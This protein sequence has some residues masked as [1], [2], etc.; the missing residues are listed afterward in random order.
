MEPNDWLR[1]EEE[2]GERVKLAEAYTSLRPKNMESTERYYGRRTG[3]G[4]EDDL[5][6]LLGGGGGGGRGQKGKSMDPKELKRKVSQCCNKM[7]EISCESRESIL[8]LLNELGTK[9]D[10]F[11]NDAITKMMESKL[12]MRDVPAFVEVASAMHCLFKPFSETLSEHLLQ[13]L[14]QSQGNAAAERIWMCVLADLVI[15]RVF[16]VQADVEKMP[17][18]NKQNLKSVQMLK[19][20]V[21]QLEKWMNLDCSSKKFEN[22]ELIWRILRHCA[23]DLFGFDFGL[24]D[25]QRTIMDPV[26][27]SQGI[28]KTSGIAQSLKKYWDDCNAERK[29]IAEKGPDLQKKAWDIRI[30]KGMLTSREGEE[31]KELKATYD[32]LTDI[33]RR[34]GFIMKKTVDEYWVDFKPDES[35]T[36]EAREVVPIAAPLVVDNFYCSLPDVDEPVD[37][38]FDVAKLRGQLSAATEKEEC[39]RLARAY[40]AASASVNKEELLA[41]INR[42]PKKRESVRYF[43]RFVAAISQKFPD[44]GAEVAKKVGDSIKGK[45][46]QLQKAPKIVLGSFI[47]PPYLGELALFDVGIDKFVEVMNFILDRFDP[48]FIDVILILAVKAGRHV[49]TC[50]DITHKQ[51]RVVLDKVKD[52]AKKF[53]YDRHLSLALKNTVEV[54]EPPAPKSEAVKPALNKYQ[55]FLRHVFLYTEP[56]NMQARLRKTAARLL[57]QQNSEVDMQFIIDLTLSLTSYRSD[58]L[59]GL[60]K[61]VADFDSH[62]PEFGF[63]VVDILMERIRRGVERDSPSYHQQQ[64]SEVRFLGALVNAEVVPIHVAAGTLALILGLNEIDP[65]GF[66]ITVESRSGKSMQR[67]CTPA[68]S[69]RVKLACALLRSMAPALAKDQG[70]QAALNLHVQWL[71][72]FVFVRTKVPIETQFC[73]HDMFEE[74]AQAGVKGILQFDDLAHLKSATVPQNWPVVT[75]SPYAIEQTTKRNTL[76]VTNVALREEEESEGEDEELIAK[77]RCE[78]E[79]WK[80]E[81]RREET[82]RQFRSI[83]PAL[84]TPVSGAPTQRMTRTGGPPANFRIVVPSAGKSN[85]DEVLSFTREC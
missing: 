27:P 22:W 37:E 83:R 53:K 3:G 15:V 71:Q 52:L 36:E 57:K 20:F 68:Q 12:K 73:L 1:S 32:R 16:P 62:Y 82:A 26:F 13:K 64:I 33:S 31:A 25:E 14:K 40:V 21:H 50:N 24:V 67:D 85:K 29:Q 59:G 17:T 10:R 66:L 55:G 51:M 61:F 18:A 72:A 54:F 44:I 30:H 63:A 70:A 49:D 28:A 78:L 75:C 74:F 80:E 69:F 77:F 84:L 2:T 7:A 19:V 39:D 76:P 8:Q 41:A 45:L 46:V 6:G 35:E 34:L 58:Q 47:S 4:A 38:E 81:A 48:R 11:V 65:R 42:A 60:G 9:L 56:E 43:A 5:F 79:E 23:G